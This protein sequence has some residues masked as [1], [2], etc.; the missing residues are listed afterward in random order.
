MN[1]KY[2]SSQPHQL[3]FALGVINGIIFM[4]LFLLYYQGVLSLG[5]TPSQFHSYSLIFLVFTPFF[6][7][8]LLTTFPRFSQTAPIEE[9][10]YM[11]IFYAMLSATTIFLIGSIFSQYIIL[12]SYAILLVATIFT[13][14][15]FYNIYKTS[16]LPTLHDQ[17]WIL[18]GWS[19]G[20][21]SQILF[22]LYSLTNIEI[23]FSL[24]KNIGIYLY[25]IVVALSVGQRMIPFFSHVSI[26]QNKNLLSMVF[27]L[28]V[29]MTI[30]KSIHINIDFIFSILAGVLL[31]KEIYS[32]KLPFRKS[33]P[34][35]WILHLAIF[36]LPIALILGGIASI[37]ELAFDQSFIF[38]QTHLVVLGFITTVLIGFGTRVTIGHSGNN[39][40][41]DKYTLILFYLT[42]IL[43]YFRILY[44]FTQYSIIFD[45]SATIWIGIF[46]A[47]SIKYFPPLLFGKK[48]N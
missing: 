12:F 22:I 33:E 48:L 42:Q 30:F 7:G 23:I 16:P 34:I 32:W 37:A 26:K 10:V 31:A 43:I 6:Q 40:V 45:I 27:T 8:F 17:F 20:I 46:L 24:T 11:K 2:I 15:I 44:S 28:L 25:L 36:W 9:K 3:F 5:I 18:M 35:L 38:I 41:I 19:M 14:Y 21:V 1:F 47:W 4:S 39:M 13:G 29:F